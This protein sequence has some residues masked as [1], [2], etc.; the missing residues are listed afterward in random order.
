LKTANK[1]E[2]ARRANSSIGLSE[3]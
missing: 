3:Y 1:D 2:R